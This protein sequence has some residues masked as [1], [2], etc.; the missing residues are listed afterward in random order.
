MAGPRV[1]LLWAGPTRILATARQDSLGWQGRVGE[2]YAQWQSQSALLLRDVR[3]LCWRQ[4]LSFSLV[5]LRVHPRLTLAGPPRLDTVS[6]AWE[7]RLG[8]YSQLGERYAH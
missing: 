3:S 5:L 1:L 7:R 2:R 8:Q 4:R 6:Q